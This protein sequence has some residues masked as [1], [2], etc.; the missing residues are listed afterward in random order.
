MYNKCFTEKSYN[1]QI[2]FEQCLLEAMQNNSYHS[3]TVKSMCDKTSISRMTFYRLFDSKDDVLYALIDRTLQEYIGFHLQAT[4]V[5]PSASAYFQRH[6]TYW[7]QKKDLLKVI[8]DNNM[9][10]ILMERAIRHITLEETNTIHQIGAD[11]IITRNET[12]RFFLSGIL[13]LL[14]QWHQTGYEKS[15]VEMS[16][17]T[18]HLLTTP[19]I[20][21]EIDIK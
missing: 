1:Q 12:L 15:I 16:S 2:I 11:N 13:E 6:Y 18:Y 8:F 7:Y 19:P 17:L 5:D 9:S 14:L 4:T 20:Q 3:I 10:S 21:D